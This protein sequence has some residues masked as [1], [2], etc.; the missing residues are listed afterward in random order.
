MLFYCGTLYA[1][2]LRYACRLN[3][4]LL[5]RTKQIT[6]KICVVGCDLVGGV[7]VYLNLFSRAFARSL[8]THSIVCGWEGEAYMNQQMREA[9]RFLVHIWALLIRSRRIKAWYAIL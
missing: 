6:T 1:N 2:T 9:N 4:F 8:Y 7:V 3:M 5:C